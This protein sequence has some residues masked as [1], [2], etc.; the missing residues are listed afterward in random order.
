MNTNQSV[1]RRSVMGT[2][3]AAAAVAAVAPGQVVSTPGQVPSKPVLT[4]E[5]LGWSQ[6]KGEYVLP[7]LPYE[8]K[9][10]E[11]HIDAR[12][13][14]IHHTKHHQAYVDGA[15][16]ALKALAGIRGGG[17][18]SLVKHWSRELSFHLGGHINHTL[19]WLGMAPAGKGGGGV[20]GGA[21]AEALAKHFGSVEAFIA[22]FKSA[23]AQVEGGGWAYLVHEPLSK[24]LLILQMEKQQDLM[25]VGCTPLLGIDV[26]EHAYYLQ[27]QNRRTA[28]VDAWF[29]VVNWTSVQ[30]RL[31][32]I[33]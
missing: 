28:Y 27:Y 17:D 12:T 5:Q 18:A 22:Q 21:L 6:A 7:P 25:P 3:A 2:L 13:M 29:N 9:A 30:S 31:T 4:P 19:F 14:E 20:P 32:A 1:D 33:S 23:A 24:S 15:N 11:P 10:L 8:V 26:W 16:K